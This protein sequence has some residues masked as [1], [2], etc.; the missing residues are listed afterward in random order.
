MPDPFFHI[1]RSLSSV[2]PFY[3]LL[4]N[5]PKQTLV[6]QKY[7]SGTT[8]PVAGAAFYVTD[9][10]GTALGQDGGEFVTDENGQIVLHDLTPGITVTARETRAA[11]GYALDTTPKSIAIQSGSVQTLTFFND[12]V[13]TVRIRKYVQGTTT[14]IPNVAFVI[15]DG[16]GAA[17]GTGEYTTNDNGEI[18]LNNIAPGTI[19]NAREIRTATGYVLNG[20]PQSLTVRSGG[21]NVLTFYDEPMVTLVIRKFVEGSDDTPIPGTE[22]KVTDGTGAVIGPE[23]GIY[24]TDAQGEIRIP[25]LTPG[26]TVT[27]RETR[28]ADGFVL[29]G[30]PQTIQ[31]QS[32]GAQSLTFWNAP[33]QTLTIRKMAEGTT[34]PIPGTAFYITDQNA[35]PLGTA[36]GEFITDADGKIVL[37]GLTPGDSITAVETR[38]ADGY[39]LDTAPKSIVIRS[40]E[41]QTLNVYNKPQGTLI[42]EKRD[43]ATNAPL[44]GAEFQILTAGGQFVDNAGGQLSSQGLY[45]TDDKGQIII[46]GLDADTLVVRE[47]KAPSGYILDDTPQTVK[48]G[49]NDTQTLTFYDQPEKV[50]TVQKFEAGTTNPIQ[51]VTFLITDGTGATVG[52]N[53]GEYTTDRNGRIV[54]TG[55]TPGTTITAK[56]IRT[57]A[58]F[59][60]DTT[61]QS[62]LMKEG[63]AQTITFYNEK[64]GGLELIK[65]DAADKTKR[66]PDTTFEV[67]SMSGGLVKKIT[68]G[69]DGRVYASLDAGDYYLVEIE[70][71]DGYK[72]DPTPEY[73][74]V[75]DGKTTTV[76]VTNVASSGILLHKT[77]AATGKALYGVTFL[78]YDSKN[79]PIGQY[80]TDNM[81]YIRIVDM[82]AG[83]YFIRELENKGYVPDTQMKT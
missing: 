16:T 20:T 33:T 1:S 69:R 27:A 9:S 51:G 39:V 7:A 11:S 46:T 49:P 41:A 58:G 37:T 32:G 72:V 48:V 81:G 6:L 62:I 2:L 55:L 29:D 12:P 35:K 23:N 10:R 53:Q 56:E 64:D 68:T 67:R 74:T 83:Q 40:G 38:A 82:E 28:A 30:T 70:A 26:Q 14:P 73:F 80:T 15:T 71:A 76:T 60:L 42:V 65:T 17:I 77:D 50:L 57:A 25:N 59:V 66:L 18:V 24:R 34:T 21:E 19:I 52:P 36:N 44:Q 78:L 4:F 31:I 75:R 63:E 47:T 13:Q 79:N 8:M 54:L 45:R 3:R 5:S 43:K 61:P 22:F